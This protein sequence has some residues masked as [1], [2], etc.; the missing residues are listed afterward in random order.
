MA[1]A[2]LIAALLLSVSA[3]GQYGEWI[4]TGRPG[5]SIGTYCLG[6]RVLQGQHGYNFRSREFDGRDGSRTKGFVNVLRLGLTEDFEV[7]GV[8]RLQHD[9]IVSDVATGSRSGVSSAQLGVRYNV[10]S[11]SGKVPSICVQTRLLLNTFDEDYG[12]EGIGQTTILAVSKSIV[13]GLGVVTNLGFTHDGNTPRARPFYTLGLSYA[14]VQRL[15]LYLETYGRFSGFDLN[16]DAGVGY[17][18]NRDLKFDVFGGL[19]GFGDF[20]G[21]PTGLEG[22]YFVSAGVSWRVDW[23]GE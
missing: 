15:Q 23:R 1:R 18:V 9:A 20:E 4:R 12:R 2:L 5:Q 11:E 16:V 17:F 3:Y 8:L 6:A 7:S 13:P 14:P 10:T 19:Q 21:D 22:D